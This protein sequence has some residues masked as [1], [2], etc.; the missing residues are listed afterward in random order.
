[1]IVYKVEDLLLE[2]YKLMNELSMSNL[3]ED[4]IRKISSTIDKL[5]FIE[6]GEYVTAII[7]LRRLKFMQDYVINK[8]IDDTPDEYKA[9]FD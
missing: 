9:A 1:M 8:M 2:I 6:K 3:K 7:V 5:E 4:D